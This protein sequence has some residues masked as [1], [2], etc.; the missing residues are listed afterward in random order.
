MWLRDRNLL[1]NPDKHFSVLATLK[2]V[3]D[4]EIKKRP[5]NVV[6]PIQG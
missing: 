5:K 6:V 2:K 3:E 1:Q 4:M